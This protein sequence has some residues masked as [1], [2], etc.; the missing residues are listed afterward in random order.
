MHKVD[1]FAIFPIAFSKIEEISILLRKVSIERSLIHLI[2]IRASQINSCA[3]CVDMHIKQ[4]KIDC[5]SELRLHHLPVWRESPAFSCRE[6]AALLWTESLTRLSEAAVTDE[7]YN[8]VK[9]HYSDGEMVELTMVISI[10]NFWN[11][12]AGPFKSV[13]GSMDDKYNLTRAG[14]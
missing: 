12:F 10:I 2:K 5:E 8:K 1:Y 3:F 13:P 4:A 11:R 7:I 9:E 6:K 14:L